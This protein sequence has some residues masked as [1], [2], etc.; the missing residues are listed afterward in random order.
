MEYLK[1]CYSVG[2]ERGETMNSILDLSKEIVDRFAK[3][4]ALLNKFEENG[5]K[6]PAYVIEQIFV[7][8]RNEK[9]EK[10]V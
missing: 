10:K 1:V 7:I 5:K 2:S 9:G 4:A 6:D 8:V 3:I